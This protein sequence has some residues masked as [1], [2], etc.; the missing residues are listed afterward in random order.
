MTKEAVAGDVALITGASSGLGA[1]FARQ[2]AARGCALILVARRVERLQKLADE[3]SVQHHVAAEVVAADLAH[4]PEMARVEQRILQCNN[5]TF[6]VNNA[7]FGSGGM[8]YQTDASRQFDMLRLHTLAPARLIRAALPGMV[9]RKRGSIINVASIAAFASVP[10]SAMYSATKRWMVSFSEALAAE[11]QNTGVRVQALCPG[12]T[13][14]EFHD[15]PAYR[16]FDRSV[17][18][19][20]LWMSADEVVRRSLSAM[21]R[22]KVVFIPGFW[23]RLNVWALRLPFVSVLA[24]YYGRRRWRDKI[25][26]VV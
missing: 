24:R 19:D 13:R 12:F 4:E 14:T 26:R 10:T 15:T 5:L 23:N 18:P 9:E 11:L 1:A 22:G 2:L 20:F 8:Y 25:N 7:G 17:V 6:L 3:L 16:D 21:E